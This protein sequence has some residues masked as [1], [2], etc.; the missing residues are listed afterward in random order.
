MKEMSVLLFEDGML[1]YKILSAHMSPKQ[2]IKVWILIDMYN[3][4]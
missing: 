1:C 4:K 3:Y 2:N